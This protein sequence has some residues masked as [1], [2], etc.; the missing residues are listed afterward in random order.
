M[1]KRVRKGVTILRKQLAVLPVVEP[2]DEYTR[3]MRLARPQTR[4]ECVDGPRPC[5][6]VSCRHH[7]YMDT[8]GGNLHVSRPTTD[9][10]DMK[11]TCS[12][13]VADE[14]ERTLEEVA[15]LMGLSRE[16]VRQIETRAL[17]KIREA[18]SEL[19]AFRYQ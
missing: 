4:G 3:Q 11:E 19:T 1:T 6:W 2:E 16:R 18:G 14:R 13:D 17:K 7:L 12:L 9:L 8:E 10:Q 5:P 15:A